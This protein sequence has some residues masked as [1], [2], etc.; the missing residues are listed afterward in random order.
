MSLTWWHARWFAFGLR[1]AVVTSVTRDD[2]PDGGAN[3]FAQTILATRAQAPDT[4]IEVL[5]P[6][7]QGSETALQA[8]IDAGPDVINHNMETVSRLYPLLRKGADYR[9]SLELL[10]R[11]EGACSGDHHKVGN[12]GWEP[13]KAGTRYADSS[14][15]SSRWDAR[16]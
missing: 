8:V 7:F 10:A 3:Q 2:L 1:H 13:A 9:R 12:Y 11:G 15:I 16:P 5:V 14:K 4:G 6:D